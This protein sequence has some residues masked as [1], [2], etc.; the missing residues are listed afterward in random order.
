M[1]HLYFFSRAVWLFGIVF[2][3]VFGGVGIVTAAQ[4]DKSLAQP[5]QQF[6]YNVKMTARSMFDGAYKY[7]DWLPIEIT[8]EN[9]GAATSVQIETVVTNTVNSTNFPTIFRRPITLGERS[10]K[11]FHIYFQPYVANSNVSRFVSYEQPIQL[12]TADGER[13]L[14]AQNV[15][16]LPISP[17]DYLVG[18]INSDPSLVSY[19]N[20]MRVGKLNSRVDIINLNPA[21]FPDRADGWR[22]FNALVLSDT[23][24]SGLSADQQNALMDW[25]NSGGQLILMG[26]NGWNKVSS[27]FDPKLL[28]IDVYD[29]QK[30]DNL[31]ALLAEENDKLPL[32]QPV[33][34]AVGQVLQGAKPLTT[35]TLTNSNSGSSVIPL[36]AARIRG[37]GRIVATAMDLTT[38]PLADW[39]GSSKAWQDIFSFN[40]GIYYQIYDDT[41]PHLKNNSDFF[42]YVG[43][44]PEV[45]L[46]NITSFF[47][48]FGIYLLVVCP[49]NYLVLVRL[50]KLVWAW[51]T[52]PI[53]GI[54]FFSIAVWLSLN[55][56]SGDVLISEMSVI[57]VSPGQTNA[58]V[59][60][61][62]A[63]FSPNDNL[64]EV[65]PV[66]PDSAAPPLLLPL[67]RN[68]AFP[69][70][71][72]DNV[73]YVVSG[74]QPRVE[75]L[76]VR[77]WSAQGV[78]VEAL[79]PAR[80][81][82]LQS[83]LYFVE[84]NGEIH[85]KG[86]V[87]NT[88]GQPIRGIMLAMGDQLQKV[89]DIEPGETLEVDF[90]LPPE[91][92]L[93][94]S[95]CTQG[96][97][98]FTGYNNTSIGEKMQNLL[99]A[100]HQNDKLYQNRA[101][102]LRKIYEIG[103]YSLTNPVRGF[104]FIGWVDN[105]P[106]PLNVAGVTTLPRSNQVLL[107]RLPVSVE[108]PLE[109][110]KI[111]IPSSYMYPENSY[112]DQ[113][114]P[115]PTSKIEHSDQICLSRG[116][117]VNNY[118]LPVD[119]LNFKTTRM[120]LILNSFT[121]NSSRTPFLPDKV[122]LF[123][124]QQNDWVV[125]NGLKNSA[126]A[127]SGSGTTP[128]SALPVLPNEID[129]PMRFTNPSTGQI[130]LRFTAPSPLLLVQFG[131]RIEGTRM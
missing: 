21:D 122:E 69:I 62:A 33:T 63:L 85:I 55:Q 9:F 83:N 15:R 90:P 56:P 68:I 36:V 50:K 123:D 129:N 59:R 118:R 58:Q 49:L 65:D 87:T 112:N 84:Q 19:M 73:R 126:P 41:N 6:E 119:N 101:A 27:G 11:K 52:L 14:F 124:W 125:L 128:N 107:S 116:T 108:N 29:Y 54:V 17:K 80:Q 70:S 44:I 89:K 12:K 23:N 10:V 72:Q 48:L 32:S 38:N 78:S 61:Y 3:F 99:Q 77:Q 57:Q 76:N 96:F 82:Q 113:G 120:V 114:A 98:N 34:I 105:N 7:G 42:G 88:I 117:V 43:N 25:V 103:R 13:T 131:I 100:D 110:G 115:I 53:T 5:N 8:L 18:V 95:F 28:P 93:V 92:Q 35:F 86:A 31:N 20:N 30:V 111:L 102:F 26:G 60:S 106:V 16:L 130:S 104:D 91:N 127:S 39:A 79:V 1:R 45:P 2:V 74:D 66:L 97:G 24:S 51:L 67:N 37:M 47:I 109:Q 94:T 121:A 4:G 46:P 40:S 81:Y 64:Y 71:D 75:Q 22:S